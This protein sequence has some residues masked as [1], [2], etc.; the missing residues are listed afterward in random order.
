MNSPAER[1]D[2]ALRT[3]VFVDGDYFDVTTRHQLKINVN[4]GS[5]FCINISARMRI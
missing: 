4:Y 3:S 5:M 2:K 1:K